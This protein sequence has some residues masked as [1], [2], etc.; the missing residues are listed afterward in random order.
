MAEFFK[1][2][3][4]R[5]ILKSLRVRFFIIVFVTGFASCFVMHT[6]ILD[7][8]EDRAVNVRSSEIQ[9]Q[10]RILANHL[11]TYNYLQDTS[12][13]V[14]NA[15]LDMLANLYDGRVMVI[16]D[17]LKVVK[18]T[19]NISQGKTIISEEVVKCL[20]TGSKGTV[21]KYDSANGYIEMITP[22]ITTEMIEEGDVTGSSTSNEV[23]RGVLLTSV[24]TDTIDTTLAILSKRATT[25][26]T[27][28][29]IVI[30]VFAVLVSHALLRPF[31]RITAAIND[32]KAGYTDDPV[33]GPNY[34]ETE[35]II[36]A[37]NALLRRM[38]VLDDSRQEFVSNV[39]HELKTPITSIKV[40]ADSLLSQENVPNEVYREFMQDIGAEIDREDK[41]INDL[42]AL[43]KMDKKASGL[44]ITSVDVVLLTEVV[45][46]RMKPIAQRRNIDLT[47][48]SKRTITAEIDEVKI[49]LVIMNLV[50]NAIKYNRDN[51]WVKVELDADHQYF[52]VKVM[53]SGIGIPGDSLDHIYE[54]FYRVDKSRSREI[55]GT[56][57]GL[58]IARN[59]VLMH[60]GTI[61]VTSTV[62]EGTIFT[63]KIPLISNG[64]KVL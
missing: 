26:E 37:F 24:S 52:T 60:R 9:T 49:S 54:R 32:V 40:L 22:I 50:E 23:V 41:I 13:E 44:N 51:G 42:L 39:S 30:L 18:D 43:V 16:N 55:G 19:Y 20:K 4:I 31:D 62:D 5:N 56:G 14:I 28:I 36:N 46:K 21:S 35:Q 25:L 1:Q 58:A 11:I 12:S 17:D 7:S 63:V 59:A 57:L 29:V 2:I 48:E 64:S 15:E 45:L 38:K 53:D 61:D 33:I 3:N 8:Y 6:L 34:Y 27:I 10:L 47:L